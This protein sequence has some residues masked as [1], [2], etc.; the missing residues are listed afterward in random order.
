MLYLTCTCSKIPSVDLA[1]HAKNLGIWE[2]C[3]KD[4]HFPGPV[5][6]EANP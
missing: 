2:I 5:M 6:R 3:N 1:F 4:N